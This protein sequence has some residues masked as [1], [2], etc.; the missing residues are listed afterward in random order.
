[1]KLKVVIL[2]RKQLFTIIGVILALILGLILLISF[3]SKETMKNV[4]ETQIVYGDVDGDKILDTIYISL[5][6]DKNYTVNIKTNKGDGY[7]LKPDPLFESF[8]NKDL[9]TPL[10]V[11]CK[12]LN[13]D[14]SQEIII[15]GENSKGTI[16]AIYTY[17]HKN[18]EFNNLLTTNDNIFGYVTLNNTPYIYLGNIDSKE[19][20]SYYTFNSQNEKSPSGLNIGLNVLNNISTTISNDNIE[21]SS[22]NYKILSN[23]SKGTI[24]DAFLLDVK[25]KK[26]IPYEYTYRIRINPY[27]NKSSIAIYEIKLVSSNLTSRESFKIKSIKTL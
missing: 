22:N 6:S 3:K 26:R 27:N 13:K 19:G 5:D 9:H 21:T 12:D 8:G 16:T 17:S 2:K 14:A 25:Y 23:I 20:V 18:N 7:T 1:M 11:E 15:Q 10:F 4:N 24:L